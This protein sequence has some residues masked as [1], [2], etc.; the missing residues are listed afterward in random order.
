MIEQNVLNEEI[1]PVFQNLLKECLNA[2]SE[3][4][5]V[6]WT[7]AGKWKIDADVMFTVSKIEEDVLDAE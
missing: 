3:I 2:D 1:I 5:N 7:Q 4:I 6:A